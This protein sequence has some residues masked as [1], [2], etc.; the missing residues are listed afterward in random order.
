MKLLGYIEGLEL[1]IVRNLW[2]DLIFPLC[3]GI[4][5]FVNGDYQKAHKF[6]S[7]VIEDCFQVGGSEVQNEVF[8][9]IYFL[10]LLK[11][12]RETEA[13]EFFNKHLAY[14]RNT[15]LAEYWFGGN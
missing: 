10:N 5:A 11:I 7:P 15:A 8:F 9:Q 13:R 12:K 1:G 14:Y 4:N 6:L 2:R 3:K